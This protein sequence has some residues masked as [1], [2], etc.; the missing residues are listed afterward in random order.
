M[1]ATTVNTDSFG[2]CQHLE[3]LAMNA[4]IATESPVF[5]M[6]TSTVYDYC[7][8]TEDIL[9]AAGRVEREAA[10]VTSQVNRNLGLTMPTNI[11]RY[12]ADIAEAAGR[13]DAAAKTVAKALHALT[14]DLDGSDFAADARLAIFGAPQS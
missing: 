14:A 8:A 1:N 5:A 4:G 6:L 9:S 3:I 13:R 10:E 2:I 12:A 7:R 11:A